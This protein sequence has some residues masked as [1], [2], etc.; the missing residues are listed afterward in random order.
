M[1]EIW[2]ELKNE[3]Q[4]DLE[5]FYSRRISHKVSTAHKHNRYDGWI[6]VFGEPIHPTRYNNRNFVLCADLT[7]EPGLE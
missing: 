2:Y 5:F 4:R 6:K 7:D 3:E 1:K